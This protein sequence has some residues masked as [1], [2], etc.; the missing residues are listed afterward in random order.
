MTCGWVTRHPGDAVPRPVL[1]SRSG[2]GVE[3]RACTR[4]DA[5]PRTLLVRAARRS[6]VRSGLG[7]RSLRSRRTAATPCRT[8]CVV[9]RCRRTNGERPEHARAD[10]YLSAASW[11]ASAG[12]SMAAATANSPPRRGAPAR[13]G[14]EGVDVGAG[15]T[16]ADGAGD[17]GGRD[18]E[19]VRVDRHA[20][21][22]AVRCGSCHQRRSLLERGRLGCAGAD[23]SVSEGSTA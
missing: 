9:S 23:T 4:N 6:A 10:G 8:G 2:T 7:V 20:P 5:V 17:G 16:V 22:R 19:V 21:H 3:H 14:V 11:M 18:V 13:F 15:E 1:T 12:F